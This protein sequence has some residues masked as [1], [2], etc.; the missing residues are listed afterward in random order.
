MSDLTRKTGKRW[1]NTGNRTIRTLPK[2]CGADIEF[3]NFVQGLDLPGGS[4]GVA[5][6][7]LLK[8]V[9]GV[10]AG[11]TSSGS[12]GTAY[13]GWFGWAGQAASWG[14]GAGSVSYG[15]GSGSREYGRV[16]LESNGGSFYIDLDH[17]EVCL[18]EVVSAWDHVACWHAMLRLANEARML[19][20]EKLSEGRR[21]QVLANNSDGLGHS[22]G[23]HMNFLIT[24]DCHDS[25]FKRR[26]HQLLFLG[27]YLTSS[28][29]FSGAGKIGCE[30]ERGRQENGPPPYQISQRADFFETLTGPQT[31]YNRP[32]VNSRDEALCGDSGRC[33]DAMA[34]LHVIFFD[35][36]LCHVSSLLKVGVTQVVLAMI[37]QD[38]LVSKLIL[39][40]PVGAVVR[41][42]HDP[43]LRERAR[44]VSGSSYTAV[45]HQLELL[46]RAR[47]FVEE[48]RAE[49]IVPRC[50]EIVDIWEDTLLKLKRRDFESLAPRLDWVLKLK[51]LERAVSRY[52]ELIRDAAQMKVLDLMYSSIDPEEGLYWFY[53]RRGEVERVVT[54]Q[55]IDRFLREPPDDTRAWLRA[56]ILRHTEAELGGE[57]H[58]VDW[59][60]IRLRVRG[61]ERESGSACRYLTLRMPDP[62]QFN[63][64]Q[65]EAVLDA[66]PS[67]RAALES[68]G[69]EETDYSG[70]PK[71]GKQV[72]LYRH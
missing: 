8:E 1:K 26:L 60:S 11:G 70:R 10:A 42:S 51:V 62:L 20:N 34:R 13:S 23:S 52:P 9:P 25:L 18:P 2:L 67:I 22:Y 40:D 21:I 7:A 43:S 68:L 55:E 19:A 3:G 17:L 69:L 72:A 24:R 36:T 41:W 46:E 31:T 16:F 57:V 66:A 53:E 29:V 71:E 5:S 32:V 54:D 48:G 64:R 63:R 14:Q 4:G 37:E 6:R 47:R 50:R 30:N 45:E 58:G 27:S 15:G 49:G 39:E 56:R 61:D 28:I 33:S 44:C 12:A 35:N 38:L 59:D 65:C